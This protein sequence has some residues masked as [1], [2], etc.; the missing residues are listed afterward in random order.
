MVEGILKESIIYYPISGLML[1]RERPREH[2]ASD[3]SWARWNTRFAGKEAGTVTGKG[4]RT[5]SIR[6]PGNPKRIFLLAHRVAL[7][8]KTGNWPVNQI[9]HINGIKY[10]N[11]FANLRDVTASENQRNKQISVNNT[12]GVMGV[13][14]HR[15]SNKWRSRITLYKKELNL[16]FFT[17]KEAAIAARKAAEIKYNFHQN[18]GRAAV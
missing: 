2:F 18:H 12:S 16:G 8:M 9:D 1:W 15:A 5:V 3:V 17:Q 4:Y 13:C 11:R 7:F 6:I 14:F 10:D